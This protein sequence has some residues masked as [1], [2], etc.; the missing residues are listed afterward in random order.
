MKGVA[1]SWNLGLPLVPLAIKLAGCMRGRFGKRRMHASRC[2]GAQGAHYYKV[3]RARLHVLVLAGSQQ[4]HQPNRTWHTRGHG[5]GRSS[6]VLSL[7]PCDIHA[8][9]Q[10]FT[11]HPSDPDP[12][13]LP[14][15]LVASLRHR[16]H[17]LPS[18]FFN[19]GA[20]HPVSGRVS[21]A[22]PTPG[23]LAVPSP[24]RGQEHARS[25]SGLSSPV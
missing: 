15:A 19:P 18:S 22:V 14:G 6:Q 1:H 24:P 12:S 13:D 25:L 21:A 3:A 10:P 17:P 9:C 11:H 7:G 4:I 2:V 16:L 8:G 20:G 5:S 23:A